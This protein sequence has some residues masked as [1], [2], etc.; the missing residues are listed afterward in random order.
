MI[1]TEERILKALMLAP[2][3]AYRLATCLSETITAVHA[4]AERLT[5]S[6]WLADDCVED[7]TG[8]W[9][10]EY[11]LSPKGMQKVKEMMS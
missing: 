2:M 3:T 9:V 5:L 4:C 10:I 11:L 6:G 7:A 1:N 8:N